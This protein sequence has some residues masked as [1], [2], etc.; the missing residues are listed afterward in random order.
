MKKVVAVKNNKFIHGT[1]NK[2]AEKIGCTGRNLT[3]HV[4][5]NKEVVAING[6]VVYLDSE[7]I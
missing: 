3:Y 7:R 1:P 4:N 5:T 2:V 6:Y